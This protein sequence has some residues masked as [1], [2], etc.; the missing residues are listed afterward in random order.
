M[1]KRANATVIIVIDVHAAPSQ[2]FV[3]AA[4]A[5]RWRVEIIWQEKNVYFYKYTHDTS[6]VSKRRARALCIHYTRARVCSAHLRLL[7]GERQR[8]RSHLLKRRLNY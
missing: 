8:V 6:C 7:F 2:F 5:V 4:Y 1:E 3:F